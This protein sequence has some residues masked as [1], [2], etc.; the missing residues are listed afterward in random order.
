MVRQKKTTN[1]KFQYTQENLERAYNAVKI[2]NVKVA[3]AS[4]LFKVP[5]ST[6]RR[7]LSGEYSL[8]MPRKCGPTWILGKH[9]EKCLVDWLLQCAK[10]GFP[11]H[12]EGLIFT[13]KKV[14][15]ELN[16]K[17][18]FTDNKLGN[19]WLYSFMKRH[20]E[21]SRKRA[22]Y[23]N[24]A[25][26]TVTEGKIRGWF[27]EVKETL[28]SDA[29]VLN[30]PETVFNMDE[31]CISLAPK[32]ELIIRPKGQ[33]VYNESSRSDKENITTL[34]SCNAAGQ[35]STPITIFKYER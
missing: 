18:P 27:S 35:F 30:H 28:G 11:D 22:E 12:K 33:H 1:P 25:R 17:T 20:P 21:L 14:I 24:C 13:V 9:T 23:V 26:G 16:L 4:K 19:K 7:R 29:D 3:A 2:D 31:T 32:G 5:R 8:N 15:E 34:F 6:L 10:M